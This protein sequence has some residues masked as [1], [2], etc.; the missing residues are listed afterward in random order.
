MFTYKK[1]LKIFQ[2]SGKFKYINYTPL[3][4][5]KTY[6]IGGVGLGLFNCYRLVNYCRSLG[7][8]GLLTMISKNGELLS[9]SAFEEGWDLACLTIIGHKV[10]CFH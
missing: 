10:A 2:D 1:C 5:S 9:I 7:I 8:L 4:N 6:N 3:K